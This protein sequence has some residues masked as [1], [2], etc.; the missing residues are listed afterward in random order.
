MH[1]LYCDETNYQK[2]P[3]DFF[4]YGGVVIRAENAL[5]LSNE[6][7]DIRKRFDVPDGYV[8]KFN[9]GP[10]DFDHKQFIELKKNIIA[11]A[12]KHECK[13]LVNLI[14]HD[15]TTS[16]E[17]ARRNS[18]DTLCHHFNEYLEHPDGFGLVMIDRFQDK[19]IE[20]E[21][22]NKLSSGISKRLPNGV[23]FKVNRIL[24]YHFTAIGQSHFC[25]VVDV[26]IGSLR[27]AINSFTQQDD[28][29]DVSAKAIFGQISPLFFRHITNKVQPSSLWFSPAFVKHDPYR[30]RY[31]E[32]VE[33]LIDQ[34][35][36]PQQKYKATSF[37]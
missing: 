35:I 6:I 23:A 9:P 32:L 33:Y 21:L 27:F 19:L 11:A 20:G 12:V 13:L 22:I 3:N 16:S 29:H 5:A 1:L 28:R 2:I 4:L 37:G 17:D 30:A 18:V 15:I 14:L 34:G 31:A 8:L 25:S 36:E 24:G 26:V 7:I 10:K